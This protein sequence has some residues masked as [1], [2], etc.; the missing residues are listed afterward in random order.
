M[1]KHEID[2]DDYEEKGGGYTGKTPKN[3]VYDAKVSTLEW[4]DSKEDWAWTF[5]ITDGPFTGWRG[6]VYTNETTSRWKLQ[7]VLKAIQGGDEK[8]MTLDDSEKGCAATVRKAGPVR[9]QLRGEEY[10]DE[11]KA[12]IVRVLADDGESKTPDSDGEDKKKKK[13]KKDK[14]GGDDPP[15]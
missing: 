4:R 14:G 2:F 8:A 7:Q 12:K 10:N 15:F 6:W 9:I 5:D 11:Q 3:G 1:S 13:K